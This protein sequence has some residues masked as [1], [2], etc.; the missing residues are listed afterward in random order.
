MAPEKTRSAP[1]SRTPLKASQNFRISVAED[2]RAA[3]RYAAQSLDLGLIFNNPRDSLKHTS[4]IAGRL[5]GRTGFFVL[6]DLQRIEHRILIALDEARPDK[7]IDALTCPYCT[8]E[9]EGR[10]VHLWLKASD[11]PID[12][13]TVFCKRCRESWTA[14]QLGWLGHL[15]GGGPR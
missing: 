1:G 5:P 9:D 3:H 7:R 10:I 11:G 15:L 6:K 14:S 12:L 8:D 2:I 4:S 13:S